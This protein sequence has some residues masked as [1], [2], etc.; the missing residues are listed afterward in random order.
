MESTLRPNPVCPGAP[1]KKPQ[2]SAMK[3]THTEAFEYRPILATHA[4][5]RASSKHGESTETWEE[6]DLKS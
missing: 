3:R 4:N 6:I 1:R 5:P 2:V